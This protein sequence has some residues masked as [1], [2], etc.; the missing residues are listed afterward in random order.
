MRV[1]VTGATGVLG[2][3]VVP[4]LVA[5]GHE[6]HAVA[7]G[8]AKAEQVAAAGGRPVELD[9]FDPVAVRAAVGE[10]R[11]E[12]V[13]HLAT[14]IPPASRALLPGAWRD[15]DRLRA[16]ASGH[17]VD[18]ALA[19]G[20]ERYV[21]ESIAFAY[22][23][24]GDDWLDE[25]TPLADGP[26]ERAVAAATRAVRRFTDAGGTGVA[27][28]FG[29]F[30]SP[31]GEHTRMMVAA[32]RA[33][34]RAVPGPAGAYQ[35]FLHA[36]DAAEAVRAALTAPAGV[37]NVVDDTPL[38]RSEAARV[39]AS[40]VGGPP[41]KLIPAGP[42]RVSRRARVLTRSQRVSSARFRAATGWA[43]AYPSLADGLPAVLAALNSGSNSDTGAGGRTV[44]TRGGGG[45]A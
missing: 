18:A 31:D 9:L 24:G 33:G 44:H 27:L 3:R 2:R 25:D 13:L 42:L 16:V 43:P 35:T 19:H 22:V 15:N 40:A 32:A 5:D 29:G 37:Y 4:L 14:H 11:P 1:L 6:A 41:A 26:T 36:D 38:R 20:V 45:P 39:L 17:L 21:Q 30:Y 28:R 10:I 7:R 23:D 12:A 8:R 34:R